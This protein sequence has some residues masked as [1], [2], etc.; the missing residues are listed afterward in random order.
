MVLGF[1][2]LTIIMIITEIIMASRHVLRP[3]FNIVMQSIK[4]AIWTIYFCLTVAGAAAINNVSSP[5]GIILS[6]VLL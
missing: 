4:S 5:V 2:V 6:L 3:V 1:A